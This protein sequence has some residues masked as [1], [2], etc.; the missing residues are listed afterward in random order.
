MARAF[1]NNP[2][3]IDQ[4]KQRSHEKLFRAV[5]A[6]YRAGVPFKQIEIKAFCQDAGVSR[7][8][9]YRRYKDLADVIV[10]HFLIVIADLKQQIDALSQPNFE[11]SSQIVVSEIEANLDLVRLVAWS[12]SQQAV[13]SV[14]SGTAQQILILRDYPASKRQFISQFLGAAI[15]NFAQE[16]SDSPEPLSGAEVL[17]LYRLLIPNSL[18]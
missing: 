16:V 6:E 5:M 9:F 10:V 18:Q 1:L 11:N 7:A 3:K 4:R 15:L 14:L 17:G 8:T 12:G 2:I 13:Q